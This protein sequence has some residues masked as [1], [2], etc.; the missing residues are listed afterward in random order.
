[1]SVADL[2]VPN[3]YPLNVGAISTPAVTTNLLTVPGAIIVAAAPTATT[4]VFNKLNINASAIYPPVE[5]F[6]AAP[7]GDIAIHLF[8]NTGTGGEFG[9]NTTEANPSAFI[10]TT[11]DVKFLAGGVEQLRLKAS[12]ISNAPLTATT[13]LFQGFGTT[14]VVSKQIAEG[15][16]VPVVTPILGF[17]ALTGITHGFYSQTGNIVHV[18]ASVVSAQTAAGVNTATLSLPIAPATPFAAASVVGVSTYS[19]AGS[20]TTAPSV[21]QPFVGGSTAVINVTSVAGGTADV[22][23]NFMYTMA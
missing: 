15:S 13:A 19:A 3:P 12:G 9:V 1:M 5:V 21:V 8:D 11:Q 20:S 4:N 7:N 14:S 6:S 16:Y 22:N 2:L 10:A 17:P 18:C 23:L